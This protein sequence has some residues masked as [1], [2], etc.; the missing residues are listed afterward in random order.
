MENIRKELQRSQ[1]QQQQQQQQKISEPISTPV[2][3]P[4]PNDYVTSTTDSLTRRSPSARLTKPTPT[5][6][7]HI[8]KVP[9]FM[10]YISQ[11]ILVLLLGL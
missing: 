2:P 10:I 4:L 11:I 7:D 1:Q 8:F 6:T 9:I 5:V 3:V